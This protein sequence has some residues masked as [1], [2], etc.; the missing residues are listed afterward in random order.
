M[1]HAAL[2]EGTSAIAVT[3]TRLVSRRESAAGE[4]TPLAD[5]PRSLAGNLKEA[6][7]NLGV[8]DLPLAVASVA[9]RPGRGR[10]AGSEVRPGQPQRGQLRLYKFR[11]RCWPGHEPP[12]TTPGLSRRWQ[13][14]GGQFTDIRYPAIPF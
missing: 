13:F 10:Q 5:F 6:S 4:K 8:S 11:E 12:R 1:D 7:L 3:L 9:R 2:S 14:K